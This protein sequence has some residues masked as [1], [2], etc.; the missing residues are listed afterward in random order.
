MSGSAKGEARIETEP[1]PLFQWAGQWSSAFILIA[2]GLFAIVAMFWAAEV[3]LNMG[4]EIAREFLVSASGIFVYIG[5]LG[6]YPAL[7]KRTPWLAR[8][9]AL[10]TVV[11][12]GGA[13]VR[14]V[15][16]ASQLVGILEAQPAWFDALQ[17]PLF[18]GI[19]LGYITF[20]VAVLRTDAYSRTVGL[21]LVVLGILFIG[22]L[23]T[24]IA[25]AGNYPYV[26]QV[27]YN[28]ANALV[29]LAIGYLLRVKDVPTDRAEPAAD[30]TAR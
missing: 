1:N 8:A 12:L 18:I 23:A 4:M 27:L 21:L 26:I 19:V 13:S 17:L 24:I 14:A 28:G 6:L 22:L 16:Y 25:M 29:L 9:A 30:T 3:F 5:L 10:F 20:G 7:I 11:G 2:G 15:V